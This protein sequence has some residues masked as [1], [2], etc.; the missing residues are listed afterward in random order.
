MVKTV[1]LK[2]ER[3]NQ[4]VKEALKRFMETNENE[5]TTFENLCDTAKAFLRGKCIAIH[6]SLKKL[7]KFQVHKLTLQLQELEKNNK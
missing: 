6:S 2:E 1:L 4:E 5:D 7:E 3:V